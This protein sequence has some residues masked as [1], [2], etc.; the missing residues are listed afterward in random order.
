MKRYQAKRKLNEQIATSDIPVW[1]GFASGD[2]VLNQVVYRFFDRNGNY[3]GWCDATTG[4]KFLMGKLYYKTKG[5]Y[6]IK[7]R[8]SYD[9]RT[10]K[11][12]HIYEKSQY[13]LAA[14]AVKQAISAEDLIDNDDRE[15]LCKLTREHIANHGFT[16]WNFAN[17]P[18]KYKVIPSDFNTKFLKDMQNF[19]DAKKQE[20]LDYVDAQIVD[21]QQAKQLNAANAAATGGD[22][23]PDGLQF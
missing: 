11:K 2:P 20:L 5:A 16:A 22:W 13:L 7:T 6:R 3:Q 4:H 9:S 21:V 10:T 23:N 17:F 19:L 1:P 8:A 15:S 12:I 18:N 14:Y